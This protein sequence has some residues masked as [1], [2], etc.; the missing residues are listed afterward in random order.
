MLTLDTTQTALVASDNKDVKWAFI[1]TDKNGVGYQYVSEPIN[2]EAWGS[3]E[4]WGTG[5]AWDSGDSLSSIVLTNFSGIE[6]RRN[7]AESGIIAP[8]EVMFSISNANNTMTPSDFK[9]GSVKIELYLGNSTYGSR[10]IAGWLFRIK[11]SPGVYQSIEVTAEDFLQYYLKGYYPNTRYPQEIFPSNRTYNNDALCVPVTFGTAYIPLRDVFITDAGYIVLGDPTYTYNISKI[12]S[13]RSWS[14]LK[15]E[16]SSTNYTFTQSTKTATDLTT[17]RVFQAIIADSDSN[18]TADAAG[19]WGTSGGPILDPPVQLTRS[20]TLSLTSPADV[21]DFVIKDLGV[22]TANIGATAIATAKTTFT[23]WALSFNG[24]YWYKQEREKVLASILNQ[25]H[26]CLDVGETIDIR[27]LSKVSK[28]TITSADVLRTVDQGPGTFKYTEL[29]N[30]DHT[31]SLYVAWQK[32]GESQDEF[33]KYLTAIGLTATEIASEVLECNFVQ[34]SENIQRIGRLYGQRKYGKEATVTWSNKGTRLYLQPDDVVTIDGDNYGS[35]AAYDVLIDS[36]KI[37]SNGSVDFLCTKFLNAFDDW[38]DPATTTLTIPTDITV[39]LWTPV[40][41]GPDSEDDSGT[42]SNNLKGRVRVGATANYILFEPDDPIQISVYEANV[43]KIRMGNLNGFLGYAS[44]VYGFAGGTLTDYIKINATAGTISI[45]GAISGGT[46][47]IGGDD[48][49]SF[50]VD[51]TG[52]LWMGAATA[53]KLIAPL[54]ITSAGALTANNAVLTCTAANAITISAGSDI[55][56]Q[57]GGDINFTAVTAPG[58]CTVAQIVTA[59]GNIPNQEYTYYV[60]FVNAYGQTEFG[61]ASVSVVVDDAHKQVALSNIPCSA[62]SSVVARKIYRTYVDGVDTIVG[63]LA[64]ISDNITTTLTDNYASVTEYNPTTAN[65]THGKLLLD[66]FPMLL[67]NNDNVALGMHAFDGNISGIYNT[68]IGSFALRSNT[69]G[70]NNVAIG[71]EALYSDTE[72]YYNVAIGYH[73]SY[74]GVGS[75]NN[76]AIGNRSLESNID[77]YRNIAIGSLSL[78]SSISG[79]QNV[80][81]GMSAL[82]CITTTHSNIGIGYS[83]GYYAVGSIANE[84]SSQSIYIG[85][86]TKS[87]V[88]GN[89]N[90]I[91]IGYNTTGAGSNTVTLGNTSITDT[92][93]RGNVQIATAKYLGLGA[94]KGRL[95][96]TDAATDTITFLDSYPIVNLDADLLGQFQRITTT[97][98]GAY[99]QIQNAHRTILGTESS[100]GATIIAG[101]LAYSTFLSSL[102]GDPLHLCVGNSAKATLLSTGY[103]GI[104]TTAPVSLAE[105]QGGLTT[106]GAVLTLGTQEPTIDANDILGRINFYAPLEASGTDAILVGASI[107][108]IAEAEFTSSV[109][110]TS[111]LF[112]TGASEVATTKMT[113]NSGGSLFVGDTSN[114]KMTVGLTINQGSNDDEIISLKSSDVAHG[115]T[116]W[117][118]TDTYGLVTKEYATFGAFS[119]RGFSE[120]NT[121]LVLYG[122]GTGENTGTTVNALAAIVA[123]SAHKDGTNVQSMSADGNIFCVRNN[124]S[125]KFIIKGDGDI[126]YDGADQ[127]AYDVY[128]DALACQDLSMN[129]SNQL[130]KVLKYNKTTLHNMGVIEYTSN[131]KGNDSLFVSRKGMDMLQ[132]GAI[133]ELYRVCTKLCGKLGITFNEAKQLT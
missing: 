111:L 49:T 124:E 88:S 93:L 92:I 20:D 67:I 91:V 128:D 113:L 71:Y 39:S 65:S 70:E 90:E 31:D 14:A 100:V 106:V 87:S 59:T 66:N 76:V 99:V 50:H 62:S 117:T 27:V 104:G 55:L 46:I 4:A 17:W 126:Y 47:D 118:E 9:G 103:L 78:G 43:E 84:T 24:G 7:S 68:V 21:F 75:L 123:N 121:A 110:A 89:T 16:Y 114:A 119:I 130:H 97:T 94:A 127:G 19:F 1:I 52:F 60:T 58:A 107:V 22:P 120:A 11:S 108:A 57:A 101:T 32:S 41:S 25:C 51:S 34:D 115:M 42:L 73:A 131:N 86:N 95:L 129:L 82:G 69:I 133:G 48:T 36:V 26:S 105:I 30:D 40:V 45:S 98:S 61:E 13:P 85:G 3:G 102:D 5:E 64:T 54:R 10:K 2:S 77:G 15:S 33:V 12:R 81:I 6:L 74:A 122:Y 116:Y 53:D 125:T 35:T 56:M 132:L 72:G 83:A 63:F 28:A 18:G 8:S 44:N 23:T 37:N 80:A 38:L 112:Q 96:F 29:I 79:D 109:N